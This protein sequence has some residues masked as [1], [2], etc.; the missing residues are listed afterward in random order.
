MGEQELSD[1]VVEQLDHIVHRPAL[2][3]FCIVGGGAEVY[4]S[5]QERLSVPIVS[6]GFQ[7][8]QSKMNWTCI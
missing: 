6:V 2:K 5:E 3:Y 1:V 8:V 4:Q 7:I